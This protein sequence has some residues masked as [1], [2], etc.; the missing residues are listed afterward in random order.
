MRLNTN[1]VKVKKQ[2]VMFFVRAAE[3]EGESRKLFKTSLL[4]LVKI[5]M[6]LIT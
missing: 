2:E 5:K 3:M 6:V 1:K 4:N